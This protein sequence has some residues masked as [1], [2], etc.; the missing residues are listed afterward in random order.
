MPA[1]VPD[2]PTRPL[3]ERVGG[4]AGVLT[5]EDETLVIKP[6]KPREIVFYEET[7]RLPA[8][9]ALRPYIPAFL[10][11][12]RLQGQQ[13]GKTSEGV[14]VVSPVAGQDATSGI[15]ESVSSTAVLLRALTVVP[16]IT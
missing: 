16:H 1:S 7:A 2:S 4:H 14:P 8:F 6:A 5:S 10:G 12:L 9:A 3:T 15:D 11:T 13:I